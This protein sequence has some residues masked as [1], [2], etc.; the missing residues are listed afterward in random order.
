MIG[1]LLMNTFDTVWNGI[2]NNFRRETT[3]KNWTAFGGYLGDMMKIVT[4]HNDY[5][6]VDAPGAINI[7]HIPKA[8]FKSVWNV[9]KGYK[10][11]KVKRY[12]LRDMTRFSKYIISIF[13][14]YEYETGICFATVVR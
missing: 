3:I 4:V 9:W 14:W 8:D 12:E 1:G 10:S 13:H 2:Q 11:K 5:I 7:Q 6:E